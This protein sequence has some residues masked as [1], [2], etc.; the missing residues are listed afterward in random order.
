MVLDYYP[1]GLKHKGYNNVINGT[2]HPY[3]FVGKEEQD[4]LGLEWIDITARNYD[5]AIGRWM[6]LDPLAEKMRKHSPYNYA[7]DNPIYFYDSDG[8][9]PGDQFKNKEAAALDFANQYNGVSINNNVEL[10]SVFYETTDAS[11]NTYTTYA[12][13]VGYKNDANEGGTAG[14][15]EAVPLPEGI[16]S[17]Q[18]T[19]DI[20]THSQDRAG[21]GHGFTENGLIPPDDNSFSDQDLDANRQRANK[22]E[23]YTAFVATPKGDLLK[24]DPKAYKTGG[25]SVT[26]IS[27][28]I[29][30][31]PNSP[32]RNSSNVSPN[33]TPDVMPLI[34]FEDGEL[35][36]ERIKTKNE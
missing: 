25:Q 8:M 2:D 13:P 31:D 7:F 34:Y 33:V 22:T 10:I 17:S 16:D 20:H 14:T 6:N 4:E 30:S 27:S 11:G 26:T 24:H 35:H 36:P 15:P 3:G 18:V 19:G 9:A 29:P 5:P 23:G 12:V 28:E 1:F 21:E 32:S